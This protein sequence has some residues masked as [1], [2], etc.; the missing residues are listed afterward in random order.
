MKS[1][2]HV[3][4]CL[5]AKIFAEQISKTTFSARLG[6]A[7]SLS[8]VAT[9]AAFAKTINLSTAR[10]T[11]DNVIQVGDGDVLTGR[12]SGYYKIAI[13]KDATVTLDNA[14]INGVYSRSY[15][16]AGITC[17]GN[18]NIV[19]EGENMVRGFYEGY[20]GIYVPE[21]NTLTISGTGSLD[22][23]TNGNA[24][25]IGGGKNIS[26]G[27]IEINGV[28]IVAKGGNF[29]AGIGGGGYGSVGNISIAGGSVTATGGASAS[30][31]G[32]GYSGTAGNISIAGGTITAT[33]GSGASGIGGGKN[34]TV[35]YIKISGND[36]KVTAI[37][38]GNAPYSIGEG[39]SGSR[40][41]DITIGDDVTASIVGSPFKYPVVQYTVTFDA[42][43][44]TGTMANQSTNID[45]ELILEANRFTR[46]GYFF[47]GWNTE[48][49]GSG[50]SYE[51]QGT[52]NLAGV[53]ESITLYAQ[54]YKSGVFNLASLTGDFIARNG[55]VLTGTLGGN[56]KITIAKNATVT[57]DNAVING[58][59]QYSYGWA[60]I[61]CLGNCNIVLEGDNTVKGF[62]SDHPGIYVPEGKTLTIS[63]SGSLDASS[64]GFAAGIGGGYNNNC[65]NI[66]INGGTIVATGGRYAPGIGG[67]YR[68]T[69]GYIKISGSDT[70]VTAIKGENAPYSIGEGD[71]GSRTGDITIGDDVTASIV[72]SP[73]KYPVVQYTVTFVANG[74]SGTMSNQ[75]TNIDPELIL[76]ANRFTREGYSFTG[77]NTEADGS[78]VSYENQ[79]HV[80][81]AGVGES[82]T[83]YAQW[84]KGSVVLL[85]A[86]TDH[87]TA[88]DGDVLTGRLGGNYKI[89]IEE[90]ATV[91]LHN[92]AINGVNE[93]SCR[94]A[95]ITCLGNCNIILN[96]KNTVKGFQVLYPGIYVPEDKKLTISGTG[97]LD[98]SSNGEGT[99]IGCGYSTSCG[100]IEINGGTIVA[101]GGLYA[102]GIGG[103]EEGT[104]GNIEINGGTIV[105]TGG[106]YAA[107]IGGGYKGTVGDIKIS[108]SDTKV[109]AIKGDETPYN[110]GEGLDGSRTGDITIGDVVT[111]SIVGSPFKYPV[112]QYTVTFDANGGS[113]TMTNQLTS[114]EPDMILEAN[115]FTREGYSFTGWNTEADGSGVS[116]GDQDN[117][118]SV[119]IGES[120]TLYAQWLE[121]N[122]I[123]LAALTGNFVAQNGVELTGVL[124]GD[125]KISIADGATV[126]LNNVIINGVNNKKYNWAGITCFG[127][128]N[129][130]LADN[131]VNEV[132]GFHEY[133]SGI[134]VPENKTLII[135]GTGSL[136]ASSNGRGAGI[137]GSY[138]NIS[139]GN[140][141]ING[142][143]IVATG[144]G[145]DAAGIGGALIGSAG[146]IVISGG[147]VTATGGSDA[148]GIGAGSRGNVGNIT[149]TDGVTKVT[150][151]K[152]G[153]ALYSIG[154]GHYDSRAGD[155]A[156]G[157]EKTGNIS[158]SPFV[159]PS[160]AYTV[161]FSKNDGSGEVQKQTIFCNSEQTLT[162]NSFVRDG[163]WFLGWNTKAD[164]SGDV[165][166]DSAKVLD[167]ANVGETLTLYA[168]WFDGDISILRNDFV[169]QDG[170][171]LTGTLAG[172]Y[173]ISIAKDATVTLNNMTINGVDDLDFKWAG[174]TCLGNC[175]ILLADGSDNNVKGFNN[176]Y[177]GIQVPYE[178][179]LVIKGNDGKLYAS[180]NGA[181]AGIGGPVRY[182]VG[183]IVIEGGDIT[184]IGGWSSAG[185][186]SSN[187]GG[188]GNIQISGGVVHATGGEYAAGIGG[189]AVFAYNNV[190]GDI[191]ISGGTVY[192]TG[193][194]YAPAIGRGDEN[195]TVGNI[196]ISGSNTKVIATKGENSAYS[197]RPN[198]NV[199]FSAGQSAL[200]GAINASIISNPFVYP[201]LIR[202]FENENEGG[203]YAAING[204]YDGS[205]AMN[206]T[207]D[208]PV[209][210]ISFKRSFTK[211]VYST[212]VLP[213]S[214]KTE[215]V[216]GL[217]AV[218]Y[219]NGIGKDANNND[220]IRMKVL[221]AADG[222]I[223]DDK[224]NPVF[225]KDTV[226][227]ANTPY[228]VL[229]NS[230][231]FAVEG[232]VTI[233]PTADA[234]TKYPEWD[235][236]FRGMWEYKVWGAQGVDKEVGYAYGFAASSP[237][238]S[239]IKV[240][241]FVKI[242][243][244]T[245][246]NPLRAY[247]VSS[248]IP[249]TTTP[250]QGIRANGAY[251]KRPTVTQKD[252]PELMSVIVDGLGDSGNGTTVIGQ[253]NTRTGEF[254][255]NNAA[256]K[257][258]FDVK[259]R[260]VGNK[261]NKARG[262]YYG[263]KVK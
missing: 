102:A 92:V 25:G 169:V 155:V 232:P 89:S 183:S 238:D 196:S 166:L 126:T 201:S 229:M 239:K 124:G 97:S 165:Y 181:A 110:I 150:V 61:T 70:K 138:P 47:D 220:A 260:N 213:F 62:Y 12:L 69:V 14:V 5:F 108:G 149:I 243:E 100:S 26:C 80:D 121:G 157:G 113:G 123:D 168:Q 85:A 192:A 84:Y 240:G 77:W 66:E 99:G 45:P 231:T 246:I 152:G 172:N 86:L 194:G 101:T 36:T 50:V 206:I 198:G 22:A 139:C 159:Y 191:E 184:A 56:Y 233:V 215:K 262:A 53:G 170:A 259:G 147:T 241:D 18:C 42:N 30:G 253:F 197:I 130:I 15:E 245:H 219:Y 167:I 10:P 128:C 182:H 214:V 28:S 98:A 188:C 60:G 178:G 225:Y 118:N 117:V 21:G 67:G 78:G 122:V 227:K 204:A 142:G 179:T 144:G 160:D 7:M 71:R 153:Y 112:V 46:E 180:S 65:G 154:S 208:I 185:I 195:G 39:D 74:G 250:T 33:G 83:L 151:T 96:R 248:N 120:L 129:I 163:F 91:T 164:G 3:F 226:M 57:L 261:A 43:G 64:N 11:S 236:E 55:D 174:I 222:V 9:T 34:G 190:V 251:V 158:K 234:V 51:D 8:L 187:D 132:K 173:K 104:V 75:S 35:G 171:V 254:K 48:A 6:L 141:E 88:K 49:D 125:Y 136:D 73:F 258:T 127:D 23:R 207:E 161:V 41:G 81:L 256:T 177:P 202:V 247:L 210:E 237:K 140:I 218:L 135:S 37:K 13:A 95:G 44:G 221:W 244:G 76:E 82:I 114:I 38:G 175:T 16:W 131:S 1:V 133:N 200:E 146:N 212:I 216:S 199:N 17:L 257:R 72:G 27:N 145:Y 94:W 255:M 249:E 4:S 68:K 31:I 40:T 115:R 109:T 193:G 252:L 58:V 203:V 90:N 24:A 116:Y 217:N 186:G 176:F 230:E 137:G 209:K 242:G 20:P 205:E 134:Y 19:L 87:Y 59:N 63:G 162:P 223:N 111:A 106:Q 52:V 143:T 224:G 105:A 54:W 119:E 79:E 156:I 211:D 93:Q 235:W 103:A 29:A 228:L 32:G 107:G 263:K 148:P 2:F 189:S